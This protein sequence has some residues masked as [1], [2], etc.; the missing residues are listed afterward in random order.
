MPL[1]DAGFYREKRIELGL[2][3]RAASIDVAARKVVL[4]N[5]PSIGWDAL[6]LATGAEPVQ[7]D[8]LKGKADVFTL[9]SFADCRSIIARVANA[10]AVVV[11]GAGFI[12][13]EAAASLKARGLDVHVVAPEAVPM[14]RQVGPELGRFL[15]GLH[16]A[17]GVALHLGRTVSAFENGR[18]R[19]DDG[20][21]IAAD[22]VLVGVGVRPRVELARAAGL[23]VNHGIAVDGRMRSSGA[24]VWA[25][26]DVAE[27]PDPRTGDQVRIEHWVVAERQGQVAAE[28]MLG[29]PSRYTDAPFFWTHQFDAE[30]RVSGLAGRFDKVE[31]EGSIEGRDCQVR[32]LREGRLTAVATLGRDKA[33]LEQAVAWEREAAP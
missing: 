21:E 33:N 20:A 4:D 31:I 32:Y 9:R 29:L 19:L 5:G 24:G 11:V 12:G 1:R 26:G 2:G 17:N 13:M 7:L 15:A 28:D 16:Q 22:F 8:A 23:A 6:L 30:L 10:R 27:Y 3:K 18:A 14:A 25:A